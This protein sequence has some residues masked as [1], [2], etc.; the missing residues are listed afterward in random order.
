MTKCPKCKTTNIRI[1][2]YKKIYCYHCNQK[3]TSLSMSQ[4]ISSNDGYVFVPSIPSYI[5]VP[6]SYE[7]SYGGGSG[8]GG[9]S[10]RSWDDGGNSYDSGYSGGCD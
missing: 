10:S 4:R 8:G 3:F 5:D 2:G 1:D 6:S 9:G 7:D